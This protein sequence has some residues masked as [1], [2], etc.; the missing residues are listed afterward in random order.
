MATTRVQ[1]ASP[2]TPS[3]SFEERFR[4]LEAQWN[5]E[6]RFLSDPGKIMGHP[7]MRAIVAL[8]EEVAPIILRTFPLFPDRTGAEEAG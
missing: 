5:A 3:E 8:G 6:T 7:A 4:K 1:K 2:V